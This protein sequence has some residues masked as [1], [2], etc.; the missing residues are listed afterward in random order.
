MILAAGGGSPIDTVMHHVQDG[1]ALDFFG[2]IVP[3]PESMLAIGITKFVIY[4]WFCAFLV[5]AFFLWVARGRTSGAPKGMY[6]A[7][8]AL[9][10]ALQKGVHEPW[11]GEKDGKIWSP[12]LWTLFFFILVNNLCGLFPMGATATGHLKVTGALAL[13]T[14][15]LIHYGAAT[16]GL[17]GYFHAMVPTVPALLFL[18]M[19]LLELAGFTFKALALM[20]RLFANMLAGH[21]L[22]LMTIS[23]IMM[24][25]KAV[26]II[27]IPAGVALYFLEIFV[28]AL[29]AFLFVF[30]SAVFIGSTLHP[31]H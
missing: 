26:A 22:L 6:N 21:I 4:M 12:Y 31:D 14:L 19:F 15:L 3:I 11:L 1:T 25:G 7:I 27:V 30:L 5:I 17:K 24:F 13:L 10:L 28:S 29:Q 2:R 20:I 8:E 16:H 18:P 23:F 9:L